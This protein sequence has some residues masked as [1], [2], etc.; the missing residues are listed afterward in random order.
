[1]FFDDSRKPTIGR[2]AKRVR[3]VD[4]KG[5][6]GMYGSALFHLAP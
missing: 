4:F 6:Y 2:M 3:E 5:S 1:M